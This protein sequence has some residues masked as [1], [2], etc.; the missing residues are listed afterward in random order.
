MRPAPARGRG[1][2]CLTAGSRLCSAKLALLLAVA[3]VLFGSSTAQAQ[4]FIHVTD[5]SI[6][7]PEGGSYTEKVWL[8]EEPTGEVTITVTVADKTIATVTPE[9]LTFDSSRWDKPQAQELTIN[10][11]DN[12][13]FDSPSQKTVV[14]L[15]A[16]APPVFLDTD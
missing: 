3:A 11:I 4:P 5:S 12:N 1:I 9:S 16:G 7:A 15:T 6:A 10:G 14:T 13:V 2:A 8:S